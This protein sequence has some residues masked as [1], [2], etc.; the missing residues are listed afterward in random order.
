MKTNLTRGVEYENFWAPMLTPDDVARRIVGAVL[1]DTEELFTPLWSWFF[2]CLKGSAILRAAP[3]RRHDFSIVPTRCID[4]FTAAFQV[5]TLPI[6]KSRTSKKIY[7]IIQYS[8]RITFF[9]I[10]HGRGNA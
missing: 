9:S 8:I 6:G 4:V 3:R 10:E 5:H 7:Q 1:T 2:V